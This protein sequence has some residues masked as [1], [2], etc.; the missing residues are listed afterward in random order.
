MLGYGFIEF[1]CLKDEFQ[2]IYRG[3][4]GKFVDSVKVK[5]LVVAGMTGG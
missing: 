2:F 1:L 4:G 3:G 5:F